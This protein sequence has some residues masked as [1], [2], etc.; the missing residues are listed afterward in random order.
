MSDKSEIENEELIKHD[1]LTP[2]PTNSE[3][4]L[5]R[6]NTRIDLTGL[7]EEQ[8]QE[9]KMKHVDDIITL[10]KKSIEADIDTRVL[11]NKLGTMGKNTAEVSQSG[12]SVTIT[13]VSE[14]SLGRT[15]TIMGDSDAAKKG[16]LSRSQTGAKDNTLY[17]IGLGAFVL[18]IIAIIASNK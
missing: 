2:V 7:T 5:L 11:G 1:E 17:W 8:I 13:N 12:S 14:D 3:S 10:Q 15:E 6:D 9:L 4:I 16:K 18:I